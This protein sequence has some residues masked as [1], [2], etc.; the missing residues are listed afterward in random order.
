MPE[1]NATHSFFCEYKI[2]FDDSPGVTRDVIRGECYPKINE[3]V[4]PE[5]RYPGTR[6]MFFS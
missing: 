2:I 1:S 3:R 5:P 6:S 4:D